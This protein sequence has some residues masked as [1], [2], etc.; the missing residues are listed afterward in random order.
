MNSCLKTICGLMRNCES[1]IEKRNE[2]VKILLEAY[3]KYQTYSESLRSIL[4]SMKT[5]RDELSIYC[6][7]ESSSAEH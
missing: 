3:E 2:Q 5:A 4:Q 7:A 1:E 6:S